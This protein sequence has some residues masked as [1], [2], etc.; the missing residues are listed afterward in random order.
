MKLFSVFKH[1][2]KKH[3]KEPAYKPTSDSYDANKLKE[4]LLKIYDSKPEV[5]AE[6]MQKVFDF[7]DITTYLHNLY[8]EF[9]SIV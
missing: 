7:I 5:N 6:E 4:V 1:Y 2:I 9:Y 3:P 8:K